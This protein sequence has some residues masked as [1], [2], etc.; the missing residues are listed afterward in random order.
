MNER[1]AM[2]IVSLVPSLTHMVCDLGLKDRI[3][4][5]TTFCVEPPGLAKTVTLIGGTKDPD[6]DKIA[7]LKPTHILVNEE[8]NKPEHIAA[9]ERLAP[10]FV[11]F[12][13]RPDE[14]PR[15]IREAGAWLEAAVAG[16]EWAAKAEATLTAMDAAVRRRAQAEAPLR[17]LYLIWREPYMVASRD[18]YIS[19]MMTMLG[20]DNV[21]PS[22]PRY[23]TMTEEQMRGVRPDVLL[24]SSEPYPFRNRDADRIRAAWPDA[25]RIE[26]IDGRL[27]S[28]YGTML[29]RAG[30]ELSWPP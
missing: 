30:R 5:A 27:M 28:W 6:L 21:A 12:P 19:G 9:C 22:T 15:L 29:V 11:T 8:E 3:V 25:P 7:A 24:L 13:K 1:N 2:R 16:E 18:T 4:G 20:L 14:V 26:K 23:P 17:A 10:T